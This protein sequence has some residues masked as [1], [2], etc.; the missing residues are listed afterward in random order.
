MKANGARAAAGA[1]AA[2]N[3]PGLQLNRHIKEIVAT[4]LLPSLSPSALTV[5]IYAAAHGDF[6]SCKVYLGA[7]TVA[8][9]AFAGARNR[10]S[11]R[12]GIAEL[13]SVG[14]LVEVKAA[15]FRQATVYRLAIVADRVNAAQERKALVGRRRRRPIGEGAHGCAPRGHM[16]D[17]P[18]GT[19]VC[20]QGAHGCAPK[21]SSNVPSSLKERYAGGRSSRRPQRPAAGGRDCRL[22][23]AAIR[24]AE[25]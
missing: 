23:R 16:D 24:R 18:G 13:L 9:R 7:K 19:S 22:G 10:T 5:L 6:T 11:A 21:H 20:P 12:A 17:P 15:T 14:F 1:G 3:S 2:D 4:G 25:S 8:A